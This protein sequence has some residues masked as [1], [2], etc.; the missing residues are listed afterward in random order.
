M[1]WSTAEFE[2]AKRGFNQTLYKIVRCEDAVKAVSIIR[3]QKIILVSLISTT[4]TA[5]Q[6]RRRTKEGRYSFGMY[7]VESM[8]IES[9]HWYKRHMDILEVKMNELK[10][11]IRVQNSNAI[12][13]SFAVNQ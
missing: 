1:A 6:R 7:Q 5:V 3:R 8:Q 4:E 13:A 2:Q 9:I 11:S 12:Q 10:L